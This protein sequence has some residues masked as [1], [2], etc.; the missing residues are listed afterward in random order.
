MVLPA[1]LKIFFAYLDNFLAMHPSA[2]GLY[3]QIGFIS[4][5]TF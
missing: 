1:S 4:G 2:I 3:G 5:N